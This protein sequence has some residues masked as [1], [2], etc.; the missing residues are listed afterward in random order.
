MDPPEFSRA[1][2]ELPPE[3]Q[4]LILGWL[5]PSDQFVCRA[6][7]STW[8]ALL[9]GAR[10]PSDWVERMARAGSLAQLE[11]ARGL[12]HPLTAKVSAQ[13]AAGGRLEVMAWLQKHGCP[14]SE[15][16]CREAALAG[17][18]EALEWLRS[19][20][21]PWSPMLCLWAAIG[22]QL[23]TVKWL[24]GVGS[25]WVEMVTTAAAMRGHLELLEW[26]HENGCPWNEKACSA[27]ASMGHFD[28]LVWLRDRG[29][30]WDADVVGLAEKH[31]R[32]DIL[33]WARDNGAPDADDAWMKHLG[34]SESERAQTAECSRKLASE[35]EREILYTNHRGEK[36]WRR[37]RPIKLWFGDTAWHAG[38]QWFLKAT[39]LEKGELRSFAV[40]DIE[41]W[42][43]A[44][45]PDRNGL[46]L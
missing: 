44:G 22:G 42:S 39:D 32:T 31:G 5:D 33:R 8:R 37:I 21:C 9:S 40:K 19:E 14:W 17:R 23:D 2:Q 4:D 34:F 26:A 38:N 36:G 1:V 15:E 18:V 28:V 20:R 45:P 35:G 41:S 11:W 3:V 7:Y 27:A 43:K 13:A 16:A 10:R 30:P 12:G 25:E 24:R 6:V 46:P 29:C